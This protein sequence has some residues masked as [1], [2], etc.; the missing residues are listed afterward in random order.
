MLV[1][2]VGF[3]FQLFTV[4]GGENTQPDPAQVGCSLQN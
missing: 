1:A 3:I 4:I 2:G